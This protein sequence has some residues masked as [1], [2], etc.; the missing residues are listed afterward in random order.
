VKFWRFFAI[1]GHER[2]ASRE[3]LADFV[4][5]EASLVA[6]KSIVD[7]CHMKTRLPIN[8]LTREKAFADAFDAARR[9]A[10]AAVA[11]DLVAAVETHLRGPASA[12]SGELPAALA[13]LYADCLERFEGGKAGDDSA[14]VERRLA[15]LQVAAPKTSAE[16][17][18]TSGNVLFDLLPIHPSLRKYDREPVVE[19][20]RFLFMSRCQRLTERLDTGALLAALLGERQAAAPRPA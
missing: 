16:I 20:V 8:E 6:Q 18:H 14:A 12:R 19:G 9:A 3:A 7:Y 11:A 13:R 15:Q 5:R 2:I 1:G 17:A 4:A 10:Y